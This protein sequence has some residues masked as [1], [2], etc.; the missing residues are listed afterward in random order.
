[1]CPTSP[2]GPP[3]LPAASCLSF[4]VF[5]CVNVSSLT[6]GVGVEQK[7]NGREKAWPFINHS[8]LAAQGTHSGGSCAR[9]WGS[10][11]S[12][13]APSPC[14]PSPSGCPEHETYTVTSGLLF[15]IPTRRESNLRQVQS[16][17]RFTDL[18]FLESS[19]LQ[20]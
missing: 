2:P 18:Y 12:P 8:A 14:T 9:R 6:G 10:P 17:Q 11:A 5:L 3:P 13:S 19:C 7:H 20:N 16:V 1:L 15:K 4:L